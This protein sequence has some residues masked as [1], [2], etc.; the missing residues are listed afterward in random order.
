MLGSLVPYGAVWRTGAN[1]ATQL[2][3]SAP[4]AI[5]GVDMA[6]GTYTVWTLPSPDG[7]QLIIN[8]QHGQWGTRYNP[9]MDLVRVALQTE[10][11]DA[12][13]DTFT[14]RIAPGTA[15]TGTLFIEWDRFRWSAPVVAR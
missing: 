12:P 1:A 10:T 4:I 7:V 13:V 15:S 2:S 14:I 9:Q 11:L 5:A 8:K 3:N 6:P